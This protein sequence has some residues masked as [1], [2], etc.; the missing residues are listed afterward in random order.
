MASPGSQWH[1]PARGQQVYPGGQVTR[2]VLEQTRNSSQTH[3]GLPK[4]YFAF[5]VKN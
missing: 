1:K 3:Q 4:V 2:V 5:K